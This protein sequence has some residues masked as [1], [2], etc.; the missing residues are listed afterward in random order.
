MKKL[1]NDKNVDYHFEEEKFF[2]ALF[3][4]LEESR[5]MVVN[6]LTLHDYAKNIKKLRKFIVQR[7]PKSEFENESDNS[8]VPALDLE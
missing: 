7:F 4:K 8:E 1:R 6:P 5:N 3:M 2:K